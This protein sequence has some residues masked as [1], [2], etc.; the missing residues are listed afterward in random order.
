MS[1]SYRRKHPKMTVHDAGGLKNFWE[2]KIE[3][4]AKQVQNENS[5]ISRSALDKLRC[6]WAQRL[7]RRLKMLQQ[8]EE[9]PKKSSLLPI[10]SFPLV[11]KTVA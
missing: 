4:H 2:K 10:E 5:R 6:E 9:G 1:K 7:E 3:H 8:P 11:D